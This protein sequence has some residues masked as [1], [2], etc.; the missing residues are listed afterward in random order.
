MVMDFSTADKAN[1]IKFCTAVHRR[2]R[3]GITHFC[4]LCSPRSPTSDKSAS[5]RDVLFMK[6]R[7]MWT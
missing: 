6:S 4:E 1:G 3:L 2:P 7:G 5:A